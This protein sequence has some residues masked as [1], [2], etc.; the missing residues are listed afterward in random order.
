MKR[1]KEYLDIFDFESAKKF[2][3]LIM[4]KKN[5]L[6]YTPDKF[7]SNTVQIVSKHNIE[8]ILVDL[9]DSYFRRLRETSNKEE[10]E[11]INQFISQK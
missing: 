2:K 6:S 10:K 3:D 9:K 4:I 11:K 7:Y 8:K 5:I 1:F